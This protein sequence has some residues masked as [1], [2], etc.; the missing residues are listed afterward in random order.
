MQQTS[1]TIL[2]ALAFLGL[3][4]C[5]GLAAPPDEE[6]ARDRYCEGEET[7]FDDTIQTQD[8]ARAVEDVTM[9]AKDD[10]DAAIEKSEGD[11]QDPAD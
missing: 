3:V 6:A 9:R 10:L 7:V 1:R 4:A 8:R 5:G 2:S 11:A